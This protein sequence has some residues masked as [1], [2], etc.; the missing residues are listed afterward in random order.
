MPVNTNGLVIRGISISNIG[1]SG[2]LAI[3]KKS[4]LEGRQ[5]AIAYANA[6]SI[7]SLYEFPEL[8]NWLNRF[9]I[10]H[11]DGSGI[12]IAARILNKPLTASSK[13]TGSDLYPL[14][15]NEAIRNKFTFYFLGHDSGTLSRISE[16]NPE[17]IVTGTHEGYN[18][19]DEEVLQD[20][21]R[22]SADILIVGLGTPKQEQW[23]AANRD[24]INSKV[25]LCVGEGIKVFAGSKSR[26]PAFL[27]SVGL[28][29]LWRFLGN[30]VKY[31]RRYII[32]NPLFLYRIISTKMRKLAQ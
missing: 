4:I 13:F 5:T 9:D 3:I 14:L 24:K 10:I 8:R 15:I 16:V 32:G 23:T 21:N 22:N 6:N 26:G 27:R 20:I 18:F 28:E 2:L 11:P 1:Y 12:R 7:N 30:P 17:L 31:F 29:W 19:R 25:I